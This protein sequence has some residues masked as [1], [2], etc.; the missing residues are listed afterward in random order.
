MFHLSVTQT[1]HLLICHPHDPALLAVRI[2]RDTWWP[3]CTTTRNVRLAQLVSRYLHAC[4]IDGCVRFLAIHAYRPAT[5]V[6]HWLVVVDA[7]QE[8]VA[9]FGWQ[10][11]AVL[12]QTATSEAGDGAILDQFCEMTSPGHDGGTYTHRGWMARAKLWIADVHVPLRVARL[13]VQPFEALA[14]RTMFASGFAVVPPAVFFKGDD[15]RPYLEPRIN[16][17]LR[18]I[19]PE[20]F[21]ETLACDTARGWWLTAAAAGR[22]LE[23]RDLVRAAVGVA[24]IQ[25]A[26]VAADDGGLLIRRDPVGLATLPGAVARCIDDLSVDVDAAGDGRSA[27][28]ASRFEQ[29]CQRLMALD[30][31]LVWVHEDLTPGN[32]LCGEE[33]LVF[34]DVGCSHRGIPPVAIVPLVELADS[35]RAR[36]SILDAYVDAWP[37]SQQAAV[38]IAAQYAP[39]VRLALQLQRHRELYEPDAKRSGM[40][41]LL[42]RGLA[43]GLRHLAAVVARLDARSEGSLDD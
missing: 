31:P 35:E 10:P 32:V 13:R 40:S 3:S 33:S 14:M 17:W 42:G 41:H 24:R 43:Y 29:V 39:A 22:P 12:R 7:D 27:Q 6:L 37:R 11:V 2:A 8:D 4:A 36:Q 19:W 26:T 21:A 1:I 15:G 28:I 34:L 23:G 38:R 30:L 5:Q 16:R 25:Q 9:P 20:A 18:G